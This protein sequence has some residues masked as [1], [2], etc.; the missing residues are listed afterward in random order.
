MEQVKDSSKIVARGALEFTNIFFDTEFTGL[1]QRTTLISLAAVA[2]TGERFYE[3]LADFDRNQVDD[4]IN[5][6]VISNLY[7]AYPLNIDQL[8]KSLE[9]WLES[10]GK[11]IMMWGDCCAYDWVLFCEIWGG[12]MNIPSYIHYIPVDFASFLKACD[13]DPDVE[14]EEFSG[15]KDH[16]EWATIG[17]HMKHNAL[18]DAE[19]LR[20]CYFRIKSIRDWESLIQ[21]LMEGVSHGVENLSES[22]SD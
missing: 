19:I 3:E 15:V 11:P 5:T 17:R 13:Q 2:E 9:K 7:K 14:R 18:W 8:R 10:F 4:W 12:A 20:L 22:E 6:N 1:H 16:R 21:K